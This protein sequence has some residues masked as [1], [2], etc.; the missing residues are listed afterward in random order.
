MRLA[1]ISILTMIFSL[2]A[3]GQTNK[4]SIT[5]TVTD[6]KGLAV[7]GAKVTVTNIGTNQSMVVNTSEG[8]TFTVPTLEPALYN[9]LVEAPNFKR[10]LIQKV[11]VD[12][13]AVATVNVGLEVGG[14]AEEVT[15]QADAQ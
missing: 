12:T 7:P 2:A 10:S 11:K 8:G 4:G 13:A 6:P 9:V 1:L 3:V 15:I 14:V 5:R